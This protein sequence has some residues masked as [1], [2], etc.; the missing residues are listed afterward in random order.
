MAEGHIQSY[1]DG[2]SSYASKD[3]VKKM[4]EDNGAPRWM[5]D[6]VDKIPQAGFSNFNDVVTSYD[7]Y[8]D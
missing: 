3:E 6:T 1:L 5:I 2:L 8:H 4:L 7:Q